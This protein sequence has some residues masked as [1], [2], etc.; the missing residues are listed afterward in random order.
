VQ[1]VAQ[2]RERVEERREAEI[3]VEDLAFQR[4]RP[5][6]KVE[7]PRPTGA[8]A[9]QP[10]AVADEAGSRLQRVVEPVVG[11]EL[12]PLRGEPVVLQVDEG[13][14]EPRL[15]EPAPRVDTDS[16]P[17]NSNSFRTASTTRSTEGM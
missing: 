13:D 4:G 11:A 14:L 6:S 3:Q 16:L 17:Q 8:P 5:A 2:D 15:V 1:G 9:F 7:R 12:R 10:Q